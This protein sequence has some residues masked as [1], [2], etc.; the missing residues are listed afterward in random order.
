M[1]KNLLLLVFVTTIAA[2]NKNK[3]SYEK[4]LSGTYTGPE[5]CNVGNTPQITFII[6]ETGS[7]ENLFITYSDNKSSIRVTA[8][9]NKFSITI[10]PQLV[11]YQGTNV[12]FSGNGNYNPET[13]QLQMTYDVANSSGSFSFSCSSTLYKK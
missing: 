6:E 12:F 13:K 7:A 11:I 3:I 10:Q 9:N 1:R 4:E 2:C 8:K 5:S